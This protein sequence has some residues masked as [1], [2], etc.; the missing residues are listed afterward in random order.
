MVPTH[1]THFWHLEKHMNSHLRDSL[2]LDL[3][4]GRF[5]HARCGLFFLA[6]TFRLSQTSTFRTKI[7]Q[8]LRK[9]VTS[10]INFTYFRIQSV[11]GSFNQTETWF[12]VR[13]F[14]ANSS[15]P[16]CSSSDEA[17]VSSSTPSSRT[18]GESSSS[19]IRCGNFWISFEM[20]LSKLL[21]SIGPSSTTSILMIRS[22]DSERMFAPSESQK[23]A[24]LSSY[25]H[26]LHPDHDQILLGHRSHAV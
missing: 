19:T 25:V 17:G 6:V 15:G 5:S 7:A 22:F 24:D 3:R 8:C 18:R 1:A 21:S 10:T 9:T 4:L 26:H 16:L 2:S 23:C 14:T 20:S 11:A 13:L 12:L